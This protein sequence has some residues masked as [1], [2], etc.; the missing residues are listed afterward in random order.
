MEATSPKLL[1]ESLCKEHHS[2]SNSGVRGMLPV[3][4][5]ELENIRVLDLRRNC[6]GFKGLQALL[7]V[8][9]RCPNLER[10]W[11]SGNHLS[12]S[13]IVELC[14]VLQDCPQL[15]LLDVSCNP[16]SNP[17]GK[18]LGRL[19][20]SLPNLS[21]VQVHGTLMNAG[22]ARRLVAQ[23][24]QKEIAAHGNFEGLRALTA[25]S[26]ESRHRGTTKKTSQEE[27][28]FGMETMWTLAAM[29]APPEGGW[30]GLA[31]VM[32]LVREDAALAAMY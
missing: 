8:V 6:I 14:N 26:R 2:H 7:G 18:A 12:N 22:L 29:A 15:E 23:A 30:S 10:L 17:A 21:V 32:A 19:V 5:S 25:V 28:W 31:S 20:Q 11:L 9:Q 4:M 16:I 27:E 3:E 24:A 1:Y 13:S